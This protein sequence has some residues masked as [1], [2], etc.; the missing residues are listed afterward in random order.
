MALPELEYSPALGAG[1]RSLPTGR[2][3]SVATGA[4]AA[5]GILTGL[6]VATGNGTLVF[7]LA[8]LL[9]AFAV[10]LVNWRWSLYGLLLYLPFAGLPSLALYPNKGPGVLAK[11]FLFVLPAYAGFFGAYVAQ[12]RRIV[13]DGAPIPLFGLVGLIVLA[14]AFN[15]SI[16]SP[17]VALIGLKVWLLYVP[18]FFLGYHFIRSKEDIDRVLWL[19]CLAAI[20]PAIIGI[21][22]AVLIYGGKS[23]FVYSLYGAAAAEATQGFAGIEVGGSFIRRVPSTFTFVFQYAMFVTSMVAIAHAA[24]RGSSRRGGLVRPGIYALMIVAAFL[25]GSRFVFVTVPLIIVFISILDGRS[26]TRSAGVLLGALTALLLASSVFGTGF[27]SLLGHL[28]SHTGHQFDLIVVKGVRQALDIT[29]IGLG[30]GTDTIAS[31]YAFD[32]TQ[33]FSGIGG[34]QESWW[35]KAWLELGIIGLIAVMALLGSIMGRALRGHRAL[36]DPQ[37]RTIS[38]SI[39]AL[40]CVALFS[41]IKQ[42][43]MDLDPL[44]V[45]FW[46]F[47]GILMKLF[48]LD[49]A[50]TGTQHRPATG[51]A[52]GPANALSRHRRPADTAAR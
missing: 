39:I 4:A 20:I 27:V 38:A 23:A 25:S 8:L 5:L 45:Y 48:A 13:F 3:P 2:R 16:P 31:R 37:L 50:G 32:R 7:A 52:G 18:L 28:V 10:G 21:V 42:Q 51:V 40:L 43:Y 1:R 11:D 29:W 49:R 9:A 47:A 44:N 33:L 15:P 6:G 46:L 34:W 22:E 14:Q 36:R 30:T 19:M 41:G 35:V 17:L 24:W 26:W 12:R